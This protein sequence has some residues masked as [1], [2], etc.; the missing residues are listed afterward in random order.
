MTNV[1]S[2]LHTTIFE[3]MSGLATRL[4]AVNLGQGF[5]ES[6]GFPDVRAAAA[7]ALIEQ[8]NQYPP[9]RG[10]MP[11]RQAVA[12]FY[13]HHQ[14]LKLESG[15]EIL[16]T[17]GATEALAASFLALID[18]GDEAIILEP[19]Y[20]AYGPLL[21]RAGARVVRLRL[22]APYW[23]LEPHAL[24]AAL[25]A[26]TRLIVVTS[27]NNPTTHCLDQAELDL[28]AEACARSGSVVISDEVWE[29]VTFKRP[30]LSVLSH[31]GLKHCAIKIGSAGKLFALT[32]WKVGW[33]CGATSLIDKLARA[34]QFLTFTTPPALQ[35]GVA[36]GLGLPARRFEEMVNEFH[37]G[38]DRLRDRLSAAGLSLLPPEGSYFLNLD[39]RRSGILGHSRDL[40]L[41][42]VQDFGVATIPLSA[43]VNGGDD[44]PFL[45]LCFAKSDATLQK[46]A[47][48]LI[49]GLKALG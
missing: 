12:D 20:D 23:R 44:L 47:D 18:P 28:L 13:A 10:L 3:E 9:M 31:P 5:P 6:D 49:T 2:G 38:Y 45:R 1:L 34:H 40:A 37:H 14:G 43:F 16:I 26:R 27:P 48:A 36:F 39:L 4:G 8:S 46:G 41:R 24:M 7:S 33:A 22:S 30:H 32:G 42:L 15:S 21:E 17:S 19:A 25:T 11:L 35:H 29:Q